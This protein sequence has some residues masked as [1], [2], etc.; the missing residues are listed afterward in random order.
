[1][2][3]SSISKYYLNEDRMSTSQSLVFRLVLLP[4]FI[5][6]P[7]EGSLQAAKLLHK[8]TFARLFLLVPLYFKYLAR[9]SKMIWLISI[10][11]GVVVPSGAVNECLAFFTM[12]SWAGTFI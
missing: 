8:T 11:E 3:D 1:M 2:S 6:Q 12:T 4:L 5:P 7:C 9:K 10:S